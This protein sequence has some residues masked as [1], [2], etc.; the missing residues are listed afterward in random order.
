VKAA[1]A[2]PRTGVPA[3]G[4]M[5]RVTDLSELT[6]RVIAPNAGH[7][8]LDGTN[9]YVIGVPGSG[10]AVVVDPGPGAPGHRARVEHV[11]RRRDL[12]CRLVMVTHHHVDHAEAAKGWADGFGCPLAAP[13]TRVVG[14]GVR[15]VLD[16]DR[17]AVSGLTL[18]AVA[19]PGHC[20]DHTAYRLPDGAL[21]S[22]DHILGRGTSVVTW[23][24]GDLAAYLSSLRKVLDLGPDAL[25]PGH[26]PEMGHDPGSVI[27]YYIEH[28]AY[29]EAQIVEAMA[30]GLDQ[31]GEMVR[32]IYADVDD[33]FWP[34][35]ECS[36][37]AALAKLVAEGRATVDGDRFRPTE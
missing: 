22:G 27:Q 8:T 33:L 7:M 21:L 30:A 28:R 9:T 23:P 34:A 12:G 37:R 13:S 20:D 17:F 3:P 29:R 6:T 1:P 26:G 11:L 2:D 5:P 25:Y 18:E 36:T 4:T 35:A 15:L 31:P 14:D 10:E 16:G 24:E 19:T 32:R